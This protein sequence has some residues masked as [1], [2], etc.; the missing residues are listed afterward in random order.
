MKPLSGQKEVEEKEPNNPF[1]DS[2]HEELIHVSYIH[3][4][5]KLSKLYRDIPES[6]LYGYLFMRN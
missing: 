2:P 3:F 4:H 5:E 1:L 6:T